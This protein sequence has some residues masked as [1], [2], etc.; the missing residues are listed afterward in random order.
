[1]IDFHLRYQHCAD[2]NHFYIQ[3]TVKNRWAVAL[4]WKQLYRETHAL[5]RG[6]FLLSSARSETVF[7][8]I[9]KLNK[10]ETKWQRTRN[11]INRRWMWLSMI[12]NVR[13]K[14]KERKSHV[15]K[16]KCLEFTW[17]YCNIVCGFTKIE[18]TW[19]YCNI[20]CGFT[21]IEITWR[22]CNIR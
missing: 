16:E 7:I 1:M 6:F 10:V 4:P 18:F 19:R 20:V 3:E 22:Y 2:R 5:M 15:I 8:I 21:K 17:R 13:V 14:T 12:K 11:F 9:A